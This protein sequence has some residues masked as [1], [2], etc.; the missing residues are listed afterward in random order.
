MAEVATPS[1]GDGKEDAGKTKTRDQIPMLIPSFTF[2]A[3][4]MLV[5]VITYRR[6]KRREDKRERMKVEMEVYQEIEMEDLISLAEMAG[7]EVIW[8]PK[9]RKRVSNVKSRSI[10]RETVAQSRGPGNG[11]VS[12][13]VTTRGRSVP[14]DPSN[15]R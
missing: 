2:A 14:S 4:L 13:Q 11:E 6:H 3:V 12:I 1:P 10:V 5:V 9:N 8:D 15:S 7:V